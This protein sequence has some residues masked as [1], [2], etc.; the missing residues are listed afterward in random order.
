MRDYDWLP[1]LAVDFPDGRLLVDYLIGAGCA[2][3]RFV[4]GSQPP[5]GRIGSHLWVRLPEH[6]DERF[7][8]RRPVLVYCAP[9]DPLDHQSL[10]RIKDL[11]RTSEGRLDNDVAFVA[12]SDRRAPERVKTWS[13]AIELVALVTSSDQRYR[14]KALSEDLGELLEHSLYG[15]D[16]YDELTPAR[17]DHFFGRAKEIN[18]MVRDVKEG[19]HC[20]LFGLRKIGK[21]SI[22]YKLRDRLS[23]TSGVVPVFVDLQATS[24]EGHAGGAAWRLGKELRKEL[25]GIDLPEA[26]VDAMLGWSERPRGD[27]ARGT[28]V[29]FLHGLGNMLEHTDQHVVVILDE[30]EVLVPPQEEPLPL[31]IELFR[32]L[33][34]IAQQTHRLSLVVAGV[35]SS[36][37]ERQSLGE[38]DNPLFSVLN[39][40]YVGPLTRSDCRDL[41]QKLGTRMG[42]RWPHNENRTLVDEVG[43]HPAL[44]RQAA[45]AVAG[46]DATRPRIVSA[47]DV[48][49]VTSDF[50]LKF[51]SRFAEMVTSLQRYYPYEYELLG[52]LVAG[53][54]A[55]VKEW[56]TV[57]P[58]AFNHLVAYGIIDETPKIAIPCFA[59]WL[60]SR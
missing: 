41:I 20:G 15:R 16:L 14:D 10:N 12:T 60:E 40:T 24:A 2:V 7:D 25:L 48:A 47:A 38:E 42:L 9:R 22:L 56:R 29:S 34:A 53:N 3:E 11:I 19:R 4:P 39:A 50:H 49:K 36:I 8:I 57:Q 35:N 6:L 32:G 52:E 30:I 58:D 46:L 54:V 51:H 55:L 5:T 37:S 44:A 59:R 26:D 21:T 33:R 18:A 13:S 45:S 43:A 1:A 28:T 17:G 31:T 27:D 23:E